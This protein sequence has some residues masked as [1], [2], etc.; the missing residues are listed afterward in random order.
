MLAGQAGGVP[1]P[2]CIS[3]PPKRLAL[4]PRRRHHQ[5]AL[6]VVVESPPS[7][8]PPSSGDL[9][10]PRELKHRRL[11]TLG[12]HRSVALGVIEQ[13]PTV[14][15]SGLYLCQ[16]V[17]CRCFATSA[18]CPK[19]CFMDRKRGHPK[20]HARGVSSNVWNR[21]RTGIRAGIGVVWLGTLTSKGTR[22]GRHHGAPRA[23]GGAG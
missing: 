13:G 23:E 10:S 7:L 2:S 9:K 1:V 5:G 4:R 17:A 19:P 8:P 14:C 6:G 11:H 16:H 20:L 21:F 22:R 18:K 3:P 12:P 15:G